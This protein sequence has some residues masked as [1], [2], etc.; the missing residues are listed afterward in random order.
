MAD[1]Q[2]GHIIDALGITM[3]LDEGDLL[4][5]VV[6]IAKSVDAGGHVSLRMATTDATTW[7]DEMA[8]VAAA[9]DI[10]RK[11]FVQRPSE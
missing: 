7:F 2:I 11:G 8:L 4:S 6:V 5:D 9:N 1:Q 10:V 3:D